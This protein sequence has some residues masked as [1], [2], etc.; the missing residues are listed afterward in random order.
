M[1]ASKITNITQTELRKVNNQIKML[2]SAPAITKH[3]TIVMFE[4]NNMTVDIG[5]GNIPFI[6]SRTFATQFTPDDAD[7]LCMKT[8]NGN[9]ERPIP[10]DELTYYTRKKEEFEELLGMLEVL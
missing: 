1:N 2:K 6:T 3:N 10:V 5:E 7:M 9:G 8:S 4:T